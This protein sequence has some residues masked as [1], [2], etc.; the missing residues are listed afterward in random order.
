MKRFYAAL[1]ALLGIFLVV[2]STALA[3]GPVYDKKYPEKE[4]ATLLSRLGRPESGVYAVT[5]SG[6]FDFDRDG[7][8]ERFFFVYRLKEDTVGKAD[9]EGPDVIDKGY[10]LV[11]I[12]GGAKAGKILYQFPFDP[13]MAALTLTDRPSPLQPA[14]VQATATMK[15]LVRSG[16]NAGTLG[17]FG[18]FEYTDLTGDKRPELI[19]SQ[20]NMGAN[21][22]WEVVT[23]FTQR[24]GQ[25]RRILD[26]V[27]SM[28]NAD[29]R[30]I[31]GD[32]TV[33]VVV[34]PNYLFH[35]L[36]K[37]N[38]F[39]WPNI[40]AFRDGR[41]VPANHLFP[42]V[43]LMKFTGLID[44][45][46][47]KDATDGGVWWGPPWEA[48]LRE[49]QIYDYNANA[50]DAAKWYRSALAGLTDYIDKAKAQSPNDK[51]LD[52]Y[53]DLKGAVERRL[54]Q[55]GAGEKGEPVFW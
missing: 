42:Q 35:R 9:S 24:K 12:K 46:R 34:C 5:G 16:G 6:S 15:K 10:W 33:E 21:T 43:Y 20:K 45:G 26:P 52:K 30:D 54:R 48:D 51:S 32:G 11:V 18:T 40:Y 28:W 41:Y 44:E 38:G 2:A 31:D 47:A 53:T 55:L 27:A 36:Y 25:W 7:K 4:I 14:S 17:Y 3:S 13:G 37:G 23:V 8:K 29:Y 22:G 50:E 19:L 39:A 49:A 1:A